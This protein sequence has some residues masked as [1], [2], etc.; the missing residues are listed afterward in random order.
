MYED[1]RFQFGNIP[2]N[3]GLKG[4][5]FFVAGEFQKGSVPPNK[6][7]VGTVRIRTRTGMGQRAFVKVAEPNT[8]ERRARVIWEKVNAAIPR[9]MLIHHIDG[10]PLNDKLANL[11]LVSRHEH[12]IIHSD[13]YA[14]KRLAGLRK[15]AKFRWEKYRR[16]H[17]RRKSEIRQKL[18]SGIHHRH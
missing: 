14:T 3:K 7:K 16:L 8:W 13:D 2:W 15:A 12:L 1:G 5:H 18:A 6:V 9:G 17:K 10:N 4:I 11:R